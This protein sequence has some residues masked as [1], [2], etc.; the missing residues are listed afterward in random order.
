MP[1][2]APTR[3]REAAV[4]RRGVELDEQAHQDGDQRKAKEQRRAAA[5]LHRFRE[6]QRRVQQQADLQ[7]EVR[8]QAEEG[9]VDQHVGD[10]AD[11]VGVDR[12]HEQQIRNQEEDDENIF[13]RPRDPH[14]VARAREEDPGRP[15]RVA[16]RQEHPQHR[17]TGQHGHRHR[18]SLHGARRA[19]RIGDGAAADAHQHVE[20]GEGE[21]AQHAHAEPLIVAEL[22]ADEQRDGSRFSRREPQPASASPFRGACAPSRAQPRSSR[23][24]VLSSPA[25]SARPACVAMSASAATEASA[26]ASTRTDTWPSASA[27]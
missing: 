22:A 14:A 3:Q 19:E 27:R 8:E 17:R 20:Q 10:V 11:D 1:T 26:G 15:K 16:A 12:G 7:H 2:T 21:Q 13:R 9:D 6:G 4:H 24:D 25:T 23:R 18:P 5:L